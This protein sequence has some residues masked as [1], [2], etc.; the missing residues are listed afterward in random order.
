MGTTEAAETV[1]KVKEATES[2]TDRG[3]EQIKGT[4]G[5]ETLFD[6]GRTGNGSDC[7]KYLI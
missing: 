2:G 6:D 3:V 7:G 1:E 5:E 4:D